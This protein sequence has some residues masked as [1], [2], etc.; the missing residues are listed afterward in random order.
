ML[1]RQSIRLKKLIEDLVEASKASTGNINVQ[2]ARTR[3]GELISQSA[4]EYGERFAAAG[5][6]PVVDCEEGLLVWADGRLLWRVLD[7]LFGNI[8]KYA[9]AGTR[10]Y[11]TARG[12]ENNRVEIVLKNISSRPLNVQPEELMERF[13][14][15]DDSRSTE[16]SGLG[17]S[18]ARSLTDLQRGEF[19]IDIDG[20]LFKATI[21]LFSAPKQE[22]TETVNPT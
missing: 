10:V 3:V 20:D 5:L 4:A 17:L 15:G 14:R 18:I 16:G 7:N 22:T 6:E 2:L 12:G 19:S 8:C 1:E 11:I 13:V 21:R 9:L